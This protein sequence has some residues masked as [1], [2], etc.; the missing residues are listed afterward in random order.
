[1][2]EKALRKAM[3]GSVGPHRKEE[4][5]PGLRA[6]FTA[7]ACYDLLVIGLVIT[8]LGPI[9]P[10]L[11][12]HFELT[13]ASVAVIFTTRGIG[14]LVSVIAGGFL[15]DAYGP[16]RV[17][18]SGG[19]C[20]GFSLL[21]TVLTKSW[22][23]VVALSVVTGIGQGLI[24]SVANVIMTDMHRK[25]PG[26]ALNLLHVWF[27]VGS[28]LGP[29]M[30]GWFLEGAENWRGVL[31]VVGAA[32]LVLAGMFGPFPYPE[33]GRTEKAA[34]QGKQGLKVLRRFA[35][36]PVYLALTAI[37]F[38]YNGVAGSIIGWV[39][40]Y[41]SS[42]FGFSTMAASMILS[43]Y[44]A[45]I[46]AGRA[47]SGAFIEKLGYGRILL[48]GSVGSFLTLLL[49]VLSPAGWL[50]ACG[51]ALTGLFFSALLPT[52]LAVGGTIFPGVM[53]AVSSSMV[54]AAALGS[55]VIPWV[56]GVLAEASSIRGAMGLNVFLLVFQA[57]AGVLAYKR[58]RTSNWEAPQ[59]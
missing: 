33:F 42:L 24:D 21:F 14:Y 27:G 43:L 3:Q 7:G 54:G 20:I 59:Q 5:S 34:T 39:N 40:V 25:S 31:A 1:M 13:P 23:L 38:L 2:A 53:G 57:L 32:G 58:L 35:G 10:F 41:L 16:K 22:G 8:T 50:A 4:V 48:I 15:A 18:V 6:L 47:L 55:M 52:A 26:R 28:F 49:A 17:V 29:L 30:A 12:R 46:L 37:A 56:T 51:Y 9:V 44:S 11:M 36:S 19:L 45:G